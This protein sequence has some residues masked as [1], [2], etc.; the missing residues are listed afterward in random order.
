MAQRQATAGVTR[1]S[2][3]VVAPTRLHARLTQ[4]SWMTSDIVRTVSSWIVAFIASPLGIV[5]LAAL[6]STVFFTFPGGVD[7]AVVILAA[8]GGAFPWIATLLA[9]AGSVAGA[10]LTFWM[11]AKIGAR[12]LKRYM[13]DARVTR[14]RR[15]LHNTGAVGM[16]VLDLMPPPFPF[17]LFILA[18]GA[19]TV[20]ATTFFVTLVVCRLIRF[21]LEAMLAGLYGMALLTWF[22]SDVFHEIVIALSLVGLTLTI[23]SLARLRIANVNRVVQ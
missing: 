13:S 23:V 2:G 8:R 20:D 19:L 5:A 22:D 3:G 16:A 1:Q 14:I 10:A 11:G 7:A 6:D 17:T 9:T 15:K 21:G 4:M 12:G 18:A